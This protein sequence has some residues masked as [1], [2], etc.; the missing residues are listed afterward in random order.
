MNLIALLNISQNFDEAPLFM[1]KDNNNSEGEIITGILVIGSIVTKTLS[2]DYN[3]EQIQ[4]AIRQ[5]LFF[6]KLLP[7][8]WKRKAFWIFEKLWNKQQVVITTEPESPKSYYE[9]TFKNQKMKDLYQ[10]LPLPDAAC[11]HMG[12]TMSNYIS[13]GLH[14]ESDETKKKIEYQ[15]GQRGLNI[16]NMVTTGDI[17]IFFE[18]INEKRIEGTNIIN[19]FNQWIENYQKISLLLAPEISYNEK[20]VEEKVKEIVVNRI[21]SYILINMSGNM[22][23]ITKLLLTVEELKQKNP[24]L[25]KEI[26][27]LINQSGVLYSIKIKICLS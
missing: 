18:E 12:N 19:Q 17:E 27:P 8:E 10:I 13:V 3:P 24:L 15:Y 5:I 11:I 14:S 22:D 9:N 21:K 20:L 23:D 6:Y 16:I 2:G 4:A 1:I 7:D 26:L 25:Y